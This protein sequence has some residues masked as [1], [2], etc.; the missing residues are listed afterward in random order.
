MTASSIGPTPAQ[1][2]VIDAMLAVIE[3]GHLPSAAS[4]GTATVLRDGAGISYGKHQ[5][6]DG[7]DTL[8][9]VVLRYIDQGGALAGELRPYLPQ[10]RANATTRID[11][12]TPWVRELLAILGRAGADPVMQRAQD[13]VF[14]ELYWHPMAR[15]AEAMGLQHALSWAVLYDTAVQSG[16]AGIGRMRRL[17]DEV[18]PVRGGD[19]RAWTTAYA[20]ARRGWLAGFVGRDDGHTAAVRRSVYRVDALLEMVRAG[21]WELR[22]PLVFRGHRIDTWG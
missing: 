21:N 16:P 18:P 14:D 7:S 12:G 8:D 3:T 22:T 5:S 17:F 20:R 2:A 1:R 6:T 10:L 9:A 11:P 15:Q 13:Q 19:E 4:Y